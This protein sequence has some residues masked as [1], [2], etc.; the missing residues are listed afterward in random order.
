MKKTM[1]EYISAKTPTQHLNNGVNIFSSPEVHYLM[2][3]AAWETW[4]YNAIQ[5]NLLD[6]I[7]FSYVED[8]ERA[9][10][11]V[12]WNKEI[13]RFDLYEVENPDFKGFN[14]TGLQG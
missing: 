8:Y 14:Y 10:F 7:Q 5:L 6:N 4:K 12:W 3:A 11:Q 1:C 9:K 13:P 2:K